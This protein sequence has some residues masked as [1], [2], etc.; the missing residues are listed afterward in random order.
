MLLFRY[1]NPKGSFSSLL[2]DDA[3]RSQTLTEANGADENDSDQH[4][5][6]D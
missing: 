2:W 5:F 1:Q 4:Q 3:I 6:N